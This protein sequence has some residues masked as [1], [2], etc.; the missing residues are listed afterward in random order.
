MKSKYLWTPLVIIAL[1][2]L[3][4]AFLPEPIDTDLGKIGNGQRSVV[5]VYDPNLVVSNQ[6]A[7]E[8]KRAREMIGEQANFLV[9]RAGDPTTDDFKQ[10]YQARSADL[11]FF[12]GDG[13]LVGRHVAVLP[14]EALI[15]R[16]SD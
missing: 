15:E 11:L 4:A 7:T 16:V 13:E 8:M 12:D 3:V 14:A 6:Q 9:V 1:I 2:V 10:Q 5:F